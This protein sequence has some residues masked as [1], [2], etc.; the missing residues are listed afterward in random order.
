[1]WKFVACRERGWN[2]ASQ[3][4]R[5]FTRS[6]ECKGSLRHRETTDNVDL[7]FA[8]EAGICDEITA[9]DLA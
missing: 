9:L 3:K 6:A 4:V 2:W 7:F 5:Q 1:M 8:D